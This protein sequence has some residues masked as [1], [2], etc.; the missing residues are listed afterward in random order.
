MHKNLYLLFASL[1]VVFLTIISL[2]ESDGLP[3]DLIPLLD[4]VLHMSAYILLTVLWSTYATKLW[5]EINL[6]RVLPIV[7]ILLTIYG[8][9]IEVLQSKLTTTRM[10]E[11]GDIV[12]NLLG[13]VFGIIIFKNIKKYKLKSNKGLFF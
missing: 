3:S 8:I 2:K 5:A 1:L 12:A 11:F 9:V 10:S 6:N 7:I 4:K 13:I